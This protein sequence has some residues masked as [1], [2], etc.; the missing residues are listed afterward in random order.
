[1]ITSLCIP[2]HCVKVQDGYQNTVPSTPSTKMVELIINDF[3]LKSGLDI[4]QVQI[5]VGLDKKEGRDIDEMYHRNLE[6]LTNKYP[7]FKVSVLSTTNYE[8]IVTASQNFLKLISVVETDNYIF[9]EH[10]WVLKSQINLLDIIN[11]VR[12]NEFVNYVRLNQF[13]NNNDRYNNLFN[14]NLNPSTNIPLVSTFRWSNNPYI[15][16]TDIFRKWWS[17]M[18]YPTHNEGGFVEGPLNELFAFFIDK[19][20]F[21]TANRKFGCYVYGNWDDESI[22]SH[23]NGNSFFI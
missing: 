23:L 12:N 21:E 5:I 10:D 18:I 2:T 16:K 7:H 9:W 8:P 20:G 17:K 15:C 1:M 11:E 22:V 3:F 6:S 13:N 19:M 4:N 14:D